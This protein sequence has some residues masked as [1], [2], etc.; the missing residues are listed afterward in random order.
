MNLDAD[1]TDMVTKLIATKCDS[2]GIVV[3]SSH[4]DVELEF[5][6]EIDVSDFVVRV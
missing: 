6:M 2:G 4:R 1:V 3:M 5:G